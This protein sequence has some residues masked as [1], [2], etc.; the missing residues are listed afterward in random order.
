MTNQ[1]ANVT[2]LTLEPMVIITIGSGQNAIVAEDSI[3]EVF[4][5][6]DVT[7]MTDRQ[8]VEGLE[9]YHMDTLEN[10]HMHELPGNYTVTR[11]TRPD[12]VMTLVV[13]PKPE[14]GI[15]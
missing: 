15:N 9:M 10:M 4:Q 2:E 12:G 13:G 5:G 14:Y 3:A 11:A 8:I 7:E 1:N 6:Q